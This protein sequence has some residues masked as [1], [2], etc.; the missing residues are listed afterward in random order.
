M[1]DGDHCWPCP[2]N[3]ICK[4][5]ALTTCNDGYTMVGS[6]CVPSTSQIEQNLVNYLFTL[7]NSFQM[8]NSFKFFGAKEN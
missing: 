8:W 2:K 7:D 1:V 6:A 4:E 5:G 3:G